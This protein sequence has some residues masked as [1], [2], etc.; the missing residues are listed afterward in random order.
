MASAE[1]PPALV[2]FAAMLWSSVDLLWLDLKS[3]SQTLHCIRA[4]SGDAAALPA[5]G[6]RSS[7]MLEAHR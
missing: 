4:A 1:R 2:A 7:T 5:A 6:R 3:R